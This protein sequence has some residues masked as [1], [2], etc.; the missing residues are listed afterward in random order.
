MTSTA[1]VAPLF[2]QLE[3]LLNSEIV[4]H[5]EAVH[6]AVLALVTGEHIFLLGP[7]GGAKSLLADRMRARIG[8]A[9][10]FKTL[11]SPFATPEGI[12]GPWDLM[13][14][15]EGRYAR[16]PEGY[17]AAVELAF[18]DEIWNASDAILHDLHMVTN[19]REVVNDGR[20]V[21]VPLSTMICA[22]NVLPQ[23]SHLTAIYDRILL[24]YV[25]PHIID[26]GNFVKMLRL[27]IDQ[28]MPIMAWADVQ[29][30]KDQVA[31]V[32]VD[33]EVF[34]A[35]TEVRRD[36]RAKNIDI[37]DRRFKRALRILQGEAWLEG[38]E[39]VDVDQIMVLTHVLWDDPAQIPDVESIL[40][41][42]A[43]PREKEALELLDE[44]AKINDLV[45]K[46]KASDN[47][48]Q[49]SALGLEAYPKVH[50]ALKQ[51]V[52]IQNDEKIGRRQLRTLAKCRE[53]LAKA[54]FELLIDVM[55]Y[56][57]DQAVSAL[58]G[59]LPPGVAGKA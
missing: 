22:S 17:L 28:P 53:D 31:A 48:E 54:A 9:R 32:A 1:S 52:S 15:K 26:D 6:G 24:R 29:T 5:Q 35:L 13:A 14:L 44:I 30:A 23:N 43:S 57:Y 19:E 11:L 25:V 20:I 51:I 37:T 36:L 50:E 40:S 34:T 4:E 10:Q 42:K 56:S 47:E 33:D 3:D 39:A 46:A 58:G 2:N 45:Q 8:N 55:K 12:F 7:P 41:E 21:P 38:L 27:S 16:L 18:I 49:Q 59:M